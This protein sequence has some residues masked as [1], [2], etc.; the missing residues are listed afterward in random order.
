M[1]LIEITFR[2]LWRGNDITIIVVN[3]ASASFK[4]HRVITVIIII[5]QYY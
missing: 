2:E 4:G 1:K 5:D 3:I